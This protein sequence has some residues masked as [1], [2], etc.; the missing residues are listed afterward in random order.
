M[1]S[2]Y[3][4]RFKKSYRL[5]P[6]RVKD[7]FDKQLIFLLENIRHPSLRAKKYDGRKDIWQARV[8]RN[9]RFYFTI[10]GDIYYLVDLIEHP[11]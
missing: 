2:V 3:S 9:W 7:D 6:E 10:K 4:N 11:K 5:A 1:L 8:N